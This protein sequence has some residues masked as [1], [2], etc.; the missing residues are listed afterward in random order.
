MRTVKRNVLFINWIDGRWVDNVHKQLEDVSVEQ[1]PY[2]L[3]YQA[4]IIVALLPERL[5][6]TETRA[7]TLMCGGIVVGET[8]TV[9]IHDVVE[10][11]SFGVVLTVAV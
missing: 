1:M 8:M 2:C 5:Q 10:L 9:F 3:L 7:L 11:M 4:V 6:R